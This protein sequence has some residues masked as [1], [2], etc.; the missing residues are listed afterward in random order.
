MSDDILED[1]PFDNRIQSLSFEIYFLYRDTIYRVGLE[2]EQQKV[3]NFQTID[4]NI[5]PQKILD[6]KLS[7]EPLVSFL[8]PSQ[9]LSMLTNG[10]IRIL[11]V[12]QHGDIS[13]LSKFYYHCKS[14]HLIREYYPD[15]SMAAL[16]TPSQIVSIQERLL[17]VA[18]EN[19]LVPAINH[20]N[21]PI[22]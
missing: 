14:A 22:Q 10:L 1:E 17:D 13:I 20:G 11:S 3:T 6:D 9:V 2:G 21:K 12:L 15:D 7:N 4:I 18:L 5:I 8:L 16:N 19:N